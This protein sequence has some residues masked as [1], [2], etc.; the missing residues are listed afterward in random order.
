M[1]TAG[2]APAG[3]AGDAPVG[4][5]GGAPVGTAG[6]APVATADPPTVGLL[7]AGEAG[8]PPK[9]RNWG[10]VRGISAAVVA[11][12][13]AVL[14]VVFS[15]TATLPHSEDAGAFQTLNEA[16]DWV[17]ANRNSSPVFLFFVNGIRL[18]IGELYGAIHGLLVSL[19]WAGVVAFGGALGL[20]LAGW[21]RGLLAAAGFASFGVLGLWDESIETF[22]LTVTAVLLSLL[23]GIP[24]GVAAG[25]SRRL[26]AVLT[27]VLDVMQ[28]MPTFAYL[29]PMALIFLIGA[30]SATIATLIYAIPPAIRIT[31]LGIQGVSPATMEASASLGSTRWQMLRTVQLPMARRTIVLAVNQTIMLALSMVVYTALIDGPGLG[32]T[33]VRALERVN[34]GTAFDAGVAI[35]VMAIVL[36]RIT[37]GASERL[38]MRREPGKRGLVVVGA[39]AG[40]AVATVA[41][42]SVPEFPEALEFSFAEPVNTAVEWVETNAFAVT[43]WFKNVVTEG[44]LNP[45]Q[46][47]LTSAP[48]WLVLGTVLA[49]GLLVTGVRAAVTAVACL[50]AVIWL[51]LWQHSMETLAI[52]LVATALTMAVG[53]GL[54]V[55][56]ARNDRLAALLRPV[57]D[58]AQT[59]PSFVYLLP[60]VALFSAS[61]F[62]AVI[63]AVIFAVPPVVRLVEDGIR[64]VPAT[65][66]EAAT[67]VGSTPVQ[68]LWKV[69]LP[70]ARRALLVATNQGIVMV[71]SMVVVGGLVGAGALGYDVVAGFAQSE[72]FGKGLAAGVAIVLLGVVLDRLTQR[73]GERSLSTQAGHAG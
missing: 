8:A 31:S 58:A 38:D 17:D 5:A 48:W 32:V 15:G 68:L 12:A 26:R 23:L 35:V 67:S 29:A 60:A 37:T 16:R 55:A 19:G 47:V 72:D 28:I 57:L 1:S 69:Q 27:P 4:T 21:R 61:R 40:A 6:D 24:L 7:R 39:L 13:A 44:L 42:R 66:V 33:I 11:L 54:G 70:V 2:G 41:G 73:P 50:G 62:T 71:L 56:A 64:G 59:M 49:V 9:V 10:R 14:Y 52:V 25:R 45:L 65:V 30:P 34:V 36:D 46:T 20:I 53:I 43:D 22:A 63:A 18:F 3:T 51:G